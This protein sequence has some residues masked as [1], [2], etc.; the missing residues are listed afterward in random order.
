MRYAAEVT[1]T[2]YVWGA[3]G[4]NNT[5]ASADA[6]PLPVQSSTFIRARTEQAARRELEKQ[7]RSRRDVVD[8]LSI[9]ITPR[10]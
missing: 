1:F 10:P 6:K 8:I 5:N 4:P 3:P 7:F 9:E 2:T